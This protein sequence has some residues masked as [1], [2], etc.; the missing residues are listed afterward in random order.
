MEYF[1]CLFYLISPASTGVAG[2]STK[3]KAMNVMPLG[4]P[5]KRASETKYI[6]KNIDF[7]YFI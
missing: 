7:A 5:P 3:D 6:F 1:T 4:W 2:E